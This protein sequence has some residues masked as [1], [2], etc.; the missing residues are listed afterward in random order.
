MPLKYKGYRLQMRYSI[1]YVV[2]V[3]GAVITNPLQYT[4]CHYS[5][6]GSGGKPVT[7]YSMS[8]QYKGSDN[9]PVTVYSMPLQYTVCP[10]RIRIT[11]TN[12][13]QYTVCIYNIN[14]LL[15]MVA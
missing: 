4:V 10:Y 3:L 2:T 13:L 12:S 6:S 9:K 1:Q 5:I 14:L 11:I 8:L 7:V 15:I